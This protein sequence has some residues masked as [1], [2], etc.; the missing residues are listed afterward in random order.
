MATFNKAQPSGAG[1]I[2]KAT[3]SQPTRGRPFLIAKIPQGIPIIQVT[4]AME[5]KLINQ[6]IIDGPRLVCLKNVGKHP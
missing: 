2:A 5:N 6:K 4:M 3:P 1:V